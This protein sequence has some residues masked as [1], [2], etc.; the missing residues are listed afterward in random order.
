MSTNNH[1]KPQ[2]QSQ[3]IFQN[4]LGLFQQGRLEEADALFLQ[5]H[6]IDAKNLD[7]LNFLGIRFYQKQEYAN[8]LR[9]LNNANELAPNSVQTLSNLGLIHHAIGDFQSA[10]QCFNQAISCNPDLPEIY[11]NRGNALKALNQT[12][13]ALSSYQQAIAL[14]PNYS[15][16]LS[17]QGV[18]FLEEGYPEKAL[19]FF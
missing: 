17:N 15:E 10:I 16:A 5:A 12:Q 1:L 13:A 9:C 6:L 7:V 11:N 4:G 2:E 3:H 19:P 8:A 18:I 14:R